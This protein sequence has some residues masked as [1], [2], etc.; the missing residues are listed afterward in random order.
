[1]AES[2]HH[3]TLIKINLEKNQQR[4]YNLHL[5]PTLFGEW[6]IVREWGRIGSGGT[7]KIN[8][9]STNEEAREKLEII[10]N[11]KIKNGYVTQ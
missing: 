11:M 10:K 5:A 4:F 6:S 1:M 7:I 3:Y 9:Y 2:D 8:T